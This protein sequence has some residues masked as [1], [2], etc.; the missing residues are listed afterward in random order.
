MDVY[1]R[2]KVSS[3][4]GNSQKI[5]ITVGDTAIKDTVGRQSL[6]KRLNSSDVTDF[7]IDIVY[8]NQTVDTNS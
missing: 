2:I 6:R 5:P 7:F 3:I 1:F 4:D 8:F